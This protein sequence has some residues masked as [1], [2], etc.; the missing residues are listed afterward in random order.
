LSEGYYLA[1][2]NTDIGSEWYKYVKLSDAVVN[3]EEALTF[4]VTTS[5]GK[6]DWIKFR[7]DGSVDADNI[8]GKLA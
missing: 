7:Q 3:G 6:W 4:T 5:D 8:A 1:I 2:G